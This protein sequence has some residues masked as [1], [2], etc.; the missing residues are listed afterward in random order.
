MMGNKAPS[1]GTIDDVVSHDKPSAVEKEYPE[2]RLT[3]TAERVCEF[4]DCYVGN[5]YIRIINDIFGY[6]AKKGYLICYDKHGNVIEYR[7]I[8]P[9]ADK[10]TPI[11][12]GRTYK[13]EKENTKPLKNKK[14]QGDSDASCDN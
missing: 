4:L 8:L 6:L 1:D 9:G 3:R 5:T 7:S 2:T 13:R 14:T 12:K 11:K 10:V